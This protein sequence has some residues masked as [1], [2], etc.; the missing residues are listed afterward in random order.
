MEK[1]ILATHAVR[2]GFRQIKG[3]SEDDARA[4]ERAREDVAPSSCH[5]VRAAARSAAAQTRDLRIVARGPGSP[6]AAGAAQ[7]VRD[8]SVAFDSVRDL[9]LR[10]GLSRTSLEKLAEADAFGS[11][12]LS[13]RDALWA[14]KGLD[15][16]SGSDLPPLFAAH[17][18]L[19]REAEVRLPRMPLGEEVVSDYAALKLSL[20]AHP[21]SFVRE[22]LAAKG[23]VTNARVAEIANGALVSTAGLVLIRQRP[24]SASGVIFVTL[25]DETGVANLVVWPKVF[26]RFR[27]QLLGARLLGV[28]GVVQK[29]G[30]VVHVVARALFDMTAELARLSDRSEAPR[31]SRD[32]PGEETRDRSALRRAAA[33]RRME[34]IMPDGRNFR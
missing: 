12:G 20:K 2:L 30:E 24:A 8:D 33:T 13:R 7:D 26:E 15:A 31:L 4:I 23:F 1:D 3:F 25:E 10:T 27:A 6:C 9:W 34:A 28:K 32:D 14:V 18:D 22:T 16:G 19:Q 5:P 17:A 29:E 21:V 11:L